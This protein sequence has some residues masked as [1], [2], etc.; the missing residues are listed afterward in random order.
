M[1]CSPTCP[2]SARR[3]PA[4]S[5]DKAG[6]RQPL[7]ALLSQ[8]LLAFA[9]EFERESDLSLAIGA[10]VLR[11]LDEKGVRVRDLPLLTGVSKEAISVA[12]GILQKQGIAVVEA[13]RGKVV[14]LTPRSLRGSGCVPVSYW[15]R[16]RNAGSRA[17]ART[18]SKPFA[19][20]LSAW[21]ATR[22]PSGRL[23]SKD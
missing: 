17:L 20:L 4:A 19:Q 8:V 7:P 3:A 23:C 21:S 10:N 2:I 9:V 13:K 6:S 5:K 12:M 22:Q 16:S 11:V 14:R 15:G 18:L 1:G